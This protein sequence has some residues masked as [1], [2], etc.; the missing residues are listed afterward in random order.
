MVNTP[1]RWS[2][3]ERELASHSDLKFSSYI[4]EGVREGFRVGFDHSVNLAGG[5][6]SPNMRSAIDHPD[7]IDQYVT[8]ELH[9]GRMLRLPPGTV[10]IHVSH[11]GVIPKPHQRGKWRLITDLSSPKGWSV[12]DGVAPSLCS[13]SY[14]SVDDAVRCILSLGVGALLAKFDMASAYRTVPVHPVDRMLLGM[15]WRET[16]LWTAHSRLG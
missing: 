11:F 5:R 4:A 3:W 16:C 9:A 1:L 6:P 8:E 2:E 12:N 13:A 10:G 7:P 15:R 14:A